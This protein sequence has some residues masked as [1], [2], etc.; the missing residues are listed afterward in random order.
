MNGQYVAFGL[1]AAAGLFLIAFEATSAPRRS[2]LMERV[3]VEI[4]TESVA[5]V[6]Q[7]RMSGSFFER[8]FLPMLQRMGDRIAR[9]TSAD[10]RGALESL[11]SAAGGVRG[12]TASQFAALEIVTAITGLILTG[13]LSVLL[14]IDTPNNLLFALAMGF[15]GFRLP[16]MRLS[17]AAR[18]RKAE[19][20]KSLP[21]ALDLLT[22][23]VEAGQSF[24]AALKNVVEQYQNPLTGELGVVLDEVRLG[25]PRNEALK[26]FA[27]RLQVDEISSFIESVLQSLQSGVPLSGALKVQSQEQRRLRRQRAEELG[28]KAPVKMLLPMVG[29]IFPTL[30]VVLLGPALV[31]I[32]SGS[33]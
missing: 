13:L 15:L 29:C 32:M 28:A 11:I 9:S 24:D 20:R 6:Q 25:K 4:E 22:I 10:G 16:R 2:R 14:A 33:S 26:A 17:S 12:M 5:A 23:S 8:V 3:G 31:L 18:K 30:F 27:D 7:D 1:V 19:M 21:A